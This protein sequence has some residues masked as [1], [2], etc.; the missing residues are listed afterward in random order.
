[1]MDCYFVINIYMFIDFA[2]FNKYN[3]VF[4]R[5]FNITVKF[6]DKYIQSKKIVFMYRMI[7]HINK[8]YDLK[9]FFA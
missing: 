2:F 7:D 8:N 5:F 3:V 6:F 1:M 9:L 4:H